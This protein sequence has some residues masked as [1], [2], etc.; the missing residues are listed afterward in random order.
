MANRRV[1]PWLSGFMVLLLGAMVLA[2]I[3]ATRPDP[4]RPMAPEPEPAPVHLRTL[5]R[6]TRERVVRCFGQTAGIRDATLACELAG[7]V[8]WRSPRM[9]AGAR[10][11]E[12]QPLL[13]LERSPFRLVR[14]RA[15]ALRDAATA[16]RASLATDLERRRANLD[17][18]LQQ[19]ELARK[20]MDRLQS[21]AR[22]GDIREAEAD[23]A[24]TAFLASELAAQN[25]SFGVSVAESALQA[26]AAAESQARVA[27]E[28]AEWD[29]DHTEVRAPFT[30]EVSQPAA[31][32]GDWLL[33]GAPVC[34][35]VDRSVL[36]VV[37]RV[38]NEDSLGLSFETPVEVRFPALTTDDGRA[39]VLEGR[40]LA[41]EPAARPDSRTREITATVPNEGL[42]LP[43]GAFAELWILRGPETAVWV[44]PA[45]VV[46]R[47]DLTLAFVADAA[48]NAEAREVV[49][50]RALIDEESRAWH[51]VLRG[52]NGGD[53]LV[54]SNLEMLT[55]GV[56]LHVL[57]SAEAPGAGRGAPAT[58]R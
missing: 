39:R 38:P 32:V 18:L 20:E 31:Q 17:K 11:E 10:I 55:D 53:R 58:G 36:R 24:R 21:L 1:S 12:G 29:L 57:D 50:G 2:G 15:A 45:E 44:R 30:G 13:R 34:R 4:P 5:E 14:D 49:L 52:L 8:V 25:G 48:N 26:A 16:D 33:P 42:S 37:A 43:V 51:P 19:E 22:T 40:L 6:E 27:L 41:F 47:G 56:P 46:L 3:Y 23:R 9:E 7:R 35:M 28:Q 54:V